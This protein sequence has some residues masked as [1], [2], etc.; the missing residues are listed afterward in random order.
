MFSKVGKVGV[1]LLENEVFTH[2]AEDNKLL[3]HTYIAHTQGRM[4]A[5]CA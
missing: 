1:A 3:A 5:L 2:F 4:S